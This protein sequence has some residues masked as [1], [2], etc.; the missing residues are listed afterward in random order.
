MTNHSYPQ[1]PIALSGEPDASRATIDP[2]PTPESLGIRADDVI[3]HGR[4]GRWWTGRDRNHC[5]SC[6]EV[7]S[8]LSGF[9][10]HQTDDGCVS[11]AKVGLVARREP[12]GVL[13]VWPG[14]ADA[15]A[16]RRA[17]GA[18]RPRPGR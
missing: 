15:L 3:R 14:D 8:S 12:W 17:G 9:D 13:W 7:I 5:G 16:R 6:H 4:C 11:P 10:A 18:V 2:Q 1:A